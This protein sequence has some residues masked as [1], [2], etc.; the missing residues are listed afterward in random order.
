MIGRTSTLPVLAAG[1]R[2]ATWMALFRPLASI[3]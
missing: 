1:I 2:D 3:R